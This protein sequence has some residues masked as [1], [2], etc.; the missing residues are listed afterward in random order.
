MMR[1]KIIALIGVKG[2]GRRTLLN[3]LINPVSGIRSLVKIPSFT[4][5]RMRSGESDGNP[6]YFI[7]SD[8][9]KRDI[10]EARLFGE[11]ILNHG[12]SVAAPIH[13]YEEELS[14]GWFPIIDLDLA[15][16]K[17]FKEKFP[18]HVIVIYVKVTDSSM[19]WRRVRETEDIIGNQYVVLDL[20]DQEMEAYADFTVHNPDGELELEMA[21]GEVRSYL[22]DIV[23]EGSTSG[24][25][26]E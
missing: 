3:S 26:P 20:Q 11:G 23:N 10:K 18:E 4:T 9:Y 17:R 7:S 14:R 15:G 22:L 6:F 16:A 25:I 12:E 21:I 2:A 8:R 19:L 5:R 24:F 13:R 1:G